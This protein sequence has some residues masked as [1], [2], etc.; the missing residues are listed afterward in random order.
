ML[1][2]PRSVQNSMQVQS[3]TLAIRTMTQLAENKHRRP[4][5]IA[6]FQ[7]QSRT[8]NSARRTFTLRRMAKFVAIPR[9]TFF[10]TQPSLESNFWSHRNEESVFDRAGCVF[11]ERRLCAG[12]SGPA[13]GTDHE[14]STGCAA[15]P[16]SRSSAVRGDCCRL[17]LLARP[18]QQL[19]PEL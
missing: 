2:P 7:A 11:R 15:R 4:S 14:D 3:P 17:F 1:Q 16:G 18:A 10:G 8:R 19:H 6:N 12:C 9:A 13:G 5:S